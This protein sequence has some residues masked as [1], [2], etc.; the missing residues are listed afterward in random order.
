MPRSL[1]VK[2]V[3]LL[4]DDE[5]LTIKIL[6]RKLRT[7]GYKVIACET[8]AQALSAFRS[9]F[10]DIVVA[11][12]DLAKDDKKK[13]DALFRAIR[14]RDW[15]VPLV[16][17]SGKLHEDS[18]KAATFANVLNFGSATFVERGTAIG[19]E[20]IVQAMRRLLERRDIVLSEMIH[21]LRSSQIKVRTT[22]GVVDSSKLLSRMLSR[23]SW[24]QGTLLSIAKAFAKWELEQSKKRSS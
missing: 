19:Y 16:L 12:W 8:Y 10:I 6:G 7:L 13:G 15:E 20:K 1:K 21:K 11:D 5:K 3:V 17:V 22:S 18:A 2:P 23:S 24:K 4:V 9:G 14:E